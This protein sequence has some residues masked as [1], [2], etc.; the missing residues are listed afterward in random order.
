MCKR[1]GIRTERDYSRAG[2]PSKLRAFKAYAAERLSAQQVAERE[3]ITLASVRE[4]GR[5]YGL[6]FAEATS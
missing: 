5:R 6:A 1:E 3:N 2:R 4:A